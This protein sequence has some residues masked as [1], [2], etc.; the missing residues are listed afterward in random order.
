M[1]MCGRFNV[2]DSPEVQS[3]LKHLGITSGQ[4]RFTPDAA[5][6]SIISIVYDSDAGPVV[7][8]AIWWLLLDPG[9]LKPNYRYATFNSRWDKL[10]SKGSLGYQPYRE[11]RCIIPASA[12]IEGLGDKRTYH[13]IQL[14]GCAIAF[15]GLYTHYVNRQTGESACAASIITLGALPQWDNIHPKSM[16]LMLPF[17]DESV[18][19]AWLDKDNQDVDQFENLLVPRV[20]ETQVVTPIGKPG[21]W[22]T[23]GPS[24]RIKPAT[25]SARNEDIS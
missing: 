6:G 17:E 15:G 22:D 21:Q 13:K 2:I 12:F 18:I 23:K 1:T 19:E 3:L 20:R 7:S 8:D 9:T 25:L 5:P 14:Q 4:L 16:P 10:N 11:R 24:W